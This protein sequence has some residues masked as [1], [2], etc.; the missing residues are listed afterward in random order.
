MTR[1]IGEMVRYGIVV[2][3]LPILASGRAE[4]LPKVAL[5]EEDVVVLLGGAN[6]VLAQR[7]GHL[8][9]L[10]VRIFS[11]RGR[12]PRF[13]NLSWEGDTVFVQSTISERWRQR[14]FGDWPGQLD[15]VGADVVLAQYGK[16]ESLD[17]EEGLPAF[18]DA[19]A[20]LI[21]EWER[22]VERIILVTPLAFE[23]TGN[24]LLPDA[25]ACNRML[26]RYA[27]VIG[28]LA[29]DRGHAFVD[30]FHPHRERVRKGE[31]WTSNGLHLRP[32][33]Q[34]EA[35]LAFARAADLEAVPI[36]E[37]SPLLAAVRERNR[38]WYEYWRPANWKCLFGDDG[39]RVFGKPAG[40]YPSLRAEW[41]RYPALVEETERRIAQLVAGVE[42]E[43]AA[44]RETGT[45]GWSVRGEAGQS[46][47]EALAAFRV[48]EGL[49]INLFASEADGLV[50]P[51]AM[52]WDADGSLH[53]A[54]SLTYPQLEP[55]EV[56]NDFILRLK[57]TDGDGRA[58]ESRVF[59]DGLCI[60]T[61][62]EVASDGIL[63]A[64]GTELLLLRDT[65]R[66]G[67]ADESRWML[68]GFGN[69]DTHQTSN[70]LVWSPGGELWW[71]QGDGIESRVETHRGVSRLFRAGVFRFRPER[72][73]LDALLD[74]FMGPGNPWGI[75]FDDWGQGLVIDGAGGI[76]HLT[77][78]MIPT[79]HRLRLP[80]IGRPG[81][82]C[83][84][85]VASGPALP[86]SLQGDFLIGDY[87]PNAV[88]RFS[89]ARKGSGFEVV[90]EDPVLSSSDTRFRPVDVKMGPDGAIY[91]CDWYNQVICH[92][93]DSFRDPGRDRAHGRIWR[94]SA[95][96][97]SPASGLVGLPVGTLVGNLASAHRWVRDQS[98]RLL[99]RGNR[100][101]V[102]EELALWTGSV[103]RGE[104]G[105][106]AAR[107]FLLMQALMTHETLDLVEES[108]LE[109]CVR[110]GDPRVRAY[111][112]RTTGRWHDRLSHPGEIL[113]RLVLDPDPLVRL[114]AI[115]ACGSIP[116]VA[117]VRTAARAM[118]LPVDTWIEYAF[119]QAVRHLEPL[120]LPALLE[121]RIDFEGRDAQLLSVIRAARSRDIAGVVAPLVLADGARPVDPG[122]RSMAARILALVGEEEHL[123]RLLE[124]GSE[125]VL[126]ALAG[127]EAPRG[128]KAALR[129]RAHLDR[130]GAAIRLAG[131]WELRELL[132]DLRTVAED[133]G[134]PV[135]IRA[136]A[137]R[138]LPG[139]AGEEDAELVRRT[140]GRV[141][142]SD[143]DHLRLAVL[144][145][146]AR[147]DAGESAEILLGHVGARHFALHAPAV[148]R[149]ILSREGGARVLA[150]AVRESGLAGDRRRLL[151]QFLIEEGVSDPDLT[152]ALGIVRRGALPPYNPSVVEALAEEMEQRGDA[153]A[154]EEVFREAHCHSCHRIA[155]A[156]GDLG[157]DLSHA[158][159]A[160]PVDRL[161]EEVLWPGRQ[162]KEG[163]S[164]L[165][166]TTR[167]GEVVQG[168]RRGERDSRDHL[169][170]ERFGDR[171]R[172]ELA[173]EGIASVEEVGSI[174]PPTAAT[175]MSRKEQRDLLRFLS[176]L[177]REGVHDQRL[178]RRWE[179][180]HQGSWTVVWSRVDGTLDPED[181]RRA[182]GRAGASTVR[183]VI[184][185]PEGRES[186]L[187]LEGTEGMEVRI[188]REIWKG[189]DA[190][191][192]PGRHELRIRIP[193]DAGS[194]IRARLGRDAVPHP[195]PDRP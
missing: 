110:A 73:Q 166:V 67:R 72:L 187:S 43:S 74:D 92:Q 17:G 172:I 37:D 105:E 69:G 173:R 137:I 26:E 107:E 183:V 36:R 8:E 129:L 98:R 65:D 41:Q 84:I 108:L 88:S 191:L 139:L 121:G 113:D 142:R 176:D 24:P 3:L 141:A 51:L 167:D 114:E 104:R 145:A 97:A 125:E 174:M 116:E 86:P 71:C 106:G 1:W 128:D 77:P 120:W 60:P 19:Y 53:V 146:L 168:Y 130:S 144:V 2:G 45:R 189:T 11:E 68:G 96:S 85:D 184:E 127:R 5:G 190:R 182:A 186:V 64:Q 52:R 136:E 28:G 6:L 193:P 30:L 9:T 40:E 58:D 143:D 111:A 59:A 42:P 29:R 188:D 165:Q 151:L 164:L 157:P 15:F 57:D 131:H 63:V 78:A 47:G 44:E 4:T 124:E 100:R 101:V 83:G 90:W 158:G 194:G 21:G 93:D 75:A 12:S 95:P 18:R 171:R 33:R 162:V 169:V 56:G 117:S 155:G 119:T 180:D 61:G 126:D 62:L 70:S 48:P 81:G 112:A 66:D 54:C 122:H 76:S 7:A 138:T 99:L 16:M 195:P 39:D 154:G 94:I 178:I 133:A 109:D 181:A 153:G 35:A 46:A 150:A 27:E 38:L 49:E 148:L 152:D 102:R 135:A 161:I 25:E 123:L 179:V 115:V 87:K 32:D 14:K 89:L 147:V 22:K 134:L 118:S 55:G 170:L 10:L 91:V 159:S 31:R 163:Y 192:P 23:P 140:I 34:W 82:Y 160:I 132:D 156:G 13:R 149:A 79:G 20:R 185:V 103:R 177:G 80:T 175:V 50:N